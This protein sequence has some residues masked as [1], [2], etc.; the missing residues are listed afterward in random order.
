MSRQSPCGRAQA[1]NRARVAR[2]YLEVAELAAEEVGDHARNVAAGN[3][4]LAGIA[5]ADAV[6]CL[7]LGA[8]HRGQDHRAA[9]DL[10]RTIRPDGAKLASDLATVLAVKDLSHYGETFVSAIKLT[11]TLRAAARLV[12]AARD[13]V[14]TT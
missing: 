13:M 1:D 4:V 6:C 14:A 12:E 10:L 5:A 7:R 2:M 3:A 8:R 9:V 11:S